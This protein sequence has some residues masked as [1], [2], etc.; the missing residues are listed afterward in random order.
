LI[1]WL[2][3]CAWGGQSAPT[4]T[5]PA[6]SLTIGTATISVEIAD[7]PAEREHGLMKRETLGTDQGMLFVYPDERPR[8]FWMKDTSL[9]LSI[10]YLDAQG[11][12]VRIADMTPFDTS[13]VPSVRPAMYALEVN[14]GWFTRHAIQVGAS[15]K[16]V[17]PPSAH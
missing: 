10:A 8:N 11:R 6:T 5:P 9:P 14:Q 4:P 2:A 12:I 16:G 1:V 7:D 13:T 3:A 17:P 15:V